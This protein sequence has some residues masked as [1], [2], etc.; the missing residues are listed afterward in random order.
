MNTDNTALAI[1][2]YRFERGIVR[3]ACPWIGSDVPPGWQSVIYDTTLGSAHDANTGTGIWI[4]PI[5]Y[6]V[7]RGDTVEVWYDGYSR[8]HAYRFNGKGRPILHE[9]SA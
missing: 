1:T 2:G 3:S 5:E 7:K 9:A 6:T 8:I 4:R